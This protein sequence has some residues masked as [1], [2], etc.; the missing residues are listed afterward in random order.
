MDWYL[1]IR[2]EKV[3]ETNEFHSFPLQE[4]F[5]SLPAVSSNFDHYLLGVRRGTELR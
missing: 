1:E 3:K 4:L 5:L 2:A